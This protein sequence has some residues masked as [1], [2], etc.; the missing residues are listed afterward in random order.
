MAEDIRDAVVLMAKQSGWSYR[1]SKGLSRRFIF[2]IAAVYHIGEGWLP[3]TDLGVVFFP[4][5]GKYEVSIRAISCCINIIEVVR[6]GHDYNNLV[7]WEA[8]NISARYA[9]VMLSGGFAWAI[10]VPSR[11]THAVLQE[12]HQCLASQTR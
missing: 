11:H 1:M 7:L 5:S 3:G 6:C 10:R 4:S 12:N 9:E 2:T 8:G